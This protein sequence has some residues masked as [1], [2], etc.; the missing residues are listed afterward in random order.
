MDQLQEHINTLS[1][2]GKGVLVGIALGFI[3]TFIAPADTRTFE[4]MHKA[5]E[6]WIWGGLVGG[7]IGLGIDGIRRGNSNTS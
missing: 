3:F 7:L 5:P 2:I 4:I 1:A 6:A